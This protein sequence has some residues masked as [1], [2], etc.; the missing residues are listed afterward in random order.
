MGHVFTGG[1]PPALGSEG[2]RYY[3][4]RVMNE[5]DG[6]VVERGVQ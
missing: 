5:N 1:S 3:I 4:P 6:M 2:K